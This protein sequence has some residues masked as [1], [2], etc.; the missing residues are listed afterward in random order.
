MRKQKIIANL[1]YFPKMDNIH[2]AIADNNNMLTKIGDCIRLKNEIDFPP[3]ISWKPIADI[4]DEEI[5]S[6][7]RSESEYGRSHKKCR[8]SNICHK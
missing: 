5:P 4:F 8:R 6:L 1:E 7:L 2:K 3:V